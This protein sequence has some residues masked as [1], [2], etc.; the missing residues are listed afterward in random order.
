MPHAERRGNQPPSYSLG[1]HEGRGPASGKTAA[2]GAEPEDLLPALAPQPRAAMAGRRA[3]TPV[4]ELVAGQAR[5]ARI[6]HRGPDSS[7][8]ALPAEPRV[9]QKPLPPRPSRSRE[10]LA[11][12]ALRCMATPALA[13]SPTLGAGGPA[14]PCACLPARSPPALLRRFKRSPH[15][16]L[17]VSP[18]SHPFLPAPVATPPRNHRK[19]NK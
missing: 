3:R 6:Q 16:S 9:E 5:A 14:Q 12:R 15:P 17:P 11:T 10:A 19:I 13:G 18:P 2:L 8:S 7:R 4:L 1:H